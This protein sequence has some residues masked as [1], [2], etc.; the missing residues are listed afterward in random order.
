MIG[1]AKVSQMKSVEKGRGA[2]RNADNNA[3]EFNGSV[4]YS[5]EDETAPLFLP[6]TEV[7]TYYPRKG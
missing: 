2:E 6:T 1:W 4:R 7:L 5:R 3:C